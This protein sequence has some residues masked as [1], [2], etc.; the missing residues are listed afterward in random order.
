M[1]CLLLELD[2]SSAWTAAAV[3]ATRQR[4]DSKA[5][6]GV[7]NRTAGTVRQRRADCGFIRQRNGVRMNLNNRQ[8]TSKSSLT[9]CADAEAFVLITKRR[10]IHRGQWRTFF[11]PYPCQLF[12]RHDVGQGLRNICYCDHRIQFYWNN[13]THFHHLKSRSTP[14][15]PPHTDCIVTT[16][17]SD[18]ISPH[19]WLCP[20]LHG[21]SG[22][23]WPNG[24][25][26]VINYATTPGFTN[27]RPTLDGC[28]YVGCIRL[29][30]GCSS[31]MQLINSTHW[32]V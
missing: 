17:Y 31:R 29:S 20:V 14:S 25:A 15:C 5:C 22:S 1:I 3:S 19:V 23:G 8:T 26:M 27:W 7:D 24:P 30:V 10:P 2:V 16:D 12:F 32:N 11:I 9:A 28:R 18:V 6:T 21:Q 13:G 4:A